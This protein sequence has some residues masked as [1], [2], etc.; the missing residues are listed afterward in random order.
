MWRGGKVLGLFRPDGLAAIGHPFNLSSMTEQAFFQFVECCKS[1]HRCGLR[2]FPS[3]GAPPILG[4]G[5]DENTDAKANCLS[6]VRRQS[7]GSSIPVSE[8]SGP[9]L[10]IDAFSGMPQLSDWPRYDELKDVFVLPGEWSDGSLLDLIRMK[11]KLF[12]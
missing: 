6:F 3:F 7:Y 10:S 4:N 9:P 11:R 1:C 2:S 8:P 12:L 5:Y